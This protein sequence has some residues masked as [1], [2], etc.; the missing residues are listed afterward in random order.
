MKV[1]AFQDVIAQIPRYVALF[2]VIRVPDLL[3]DY[4][5]MNEMV[6]FIPEQDAFKT[7]NGKLIKLAPSNVHFEGYVP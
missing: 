4:V 2:S 7:E 3:K 5:Q 1:K 6:Y